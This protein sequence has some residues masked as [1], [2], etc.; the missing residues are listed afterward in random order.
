M[1]Q[2]LTDFGSVDC[3]DPHDRD[4]PPQDNS[5]VTK[6]FAFTSSV[7]NVK[8]HLKTL[9]ASGGGDGPEGVTAGMKAALELDWR[10]SAAKMTVLIADAPCHGIG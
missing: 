2:S 5:Y 10:P 7:A 4:Y 1:P 8:E 6:S 9:Y 3:S